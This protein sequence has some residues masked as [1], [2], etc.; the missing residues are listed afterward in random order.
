MEIKS[1]RI[2]NWRKGI[3]HLYPSHVDI[4]FNV[5]LQVL[6]GLCFQ[7]DNITP[8]ISCNTVNQRNGLFSTSW[9]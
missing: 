8:D 3:R 1:T 2:H 6:D 4:F 9:S 7:N 5:L